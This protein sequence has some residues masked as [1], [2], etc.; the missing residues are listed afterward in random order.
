MVE[1]LGLSLS[2]LYPADRPDAVTSTLTDQTPTDASTST[3]AVNPKPEVVEVQ[4]PVLNRTPSKAKSLQILIIKKY[5]IAPVASGDSSLSHQKIPREITNY[6]NSVHSLDLELHHFWRRNKALYP[7]LY[8]LAKGVQAVPA[9][10]AEIER[11]WRSYGPILSSRRFC[12]E[13]KNYNH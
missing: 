12:I 6:T 9:T 8:Q 5:S 2:K 7:G 11:V 1:D 10:S 13:P 4:P 3:D